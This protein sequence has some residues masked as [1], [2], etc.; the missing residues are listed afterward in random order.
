M[1]MF[2]KV[3][4]VS[5]R[6]HCFHPRQ[7]CWRHYAVWP[8]IDQNQAFAGLIGCRLWAQRRLLYMQVMVLA[9]MYISKRAT[10]L[11][12]RWAQP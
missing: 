10:A 9:R 3:M 7:F 5:S 11:P 12:L 8:T 4:N 1:L 2:A 6:V